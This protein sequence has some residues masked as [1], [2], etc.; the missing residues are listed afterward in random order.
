MQRHDLDLISLVP[1]VLF[2]LIGLALLNGV[3]L[4][5]V[6]LRWTVPALAVAA[7]VLI[8]VQ[9]VRRAGDGEDG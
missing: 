6:D 4:L 3:D 1:G 2:T 5:Q 9:V 8:L 7:G